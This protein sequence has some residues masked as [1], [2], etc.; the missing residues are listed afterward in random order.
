SFGQGKVV[1]LE[2]W[3]AERN[4]SLEGAWFYSDSRNDLPLLERV[5]NPIAV[6]PDQTLRDIAQTNGWPILDLRKPA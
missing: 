1:R 3:L 2:Q 4:E 6:N 5:D